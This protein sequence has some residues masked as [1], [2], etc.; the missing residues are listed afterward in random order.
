M[1]VGIS[2]SKKKKEEEE[3]PK[4]IRDS[5]Y[6]GRFCV[7]MRAKLIIFRLVTGQQKLD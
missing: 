1:K 7:W 5:I 6:K 2:H 4:K 3:E